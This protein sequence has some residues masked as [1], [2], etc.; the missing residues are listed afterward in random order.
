LTARRSWLR[1]SSTA[2]VSCPHSC[3]QAQSTTVTWSSDPHEGRCITWGKS[4]SNTSGESGGHVDYYTSWLRLGTNQG[5]S[6]PTRCQPAAGITR[7]SSAALA[8]VLRN[9]GRTIRNF[10]KGEAE[11]GIIV[12]HGLPF[13]CPMLVVSAGCW[14]LTVR[15][16]LQASPTSLETS[17][18]QAPPAC[19]SQRQAVL[20]LHFQQ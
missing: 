8:G 14:S 16:R 19:S 10:R 13:D 11:R 2:A 6:S 20:E 17:I 3:Q 1:L 18:F 9:L 15:E 7:C 12:G 5:S 4:T